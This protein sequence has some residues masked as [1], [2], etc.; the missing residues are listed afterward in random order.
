MA[1]DD[2]PTEE[3]V[4]VPAEPETP[5]ETPKEE[6]PE[7]TPEEQ[8][9][10]DAL[11]QVN[12][13][14]KG[15]LK[16]N[17]PLDEEPPEPTEEP[18]EP[19]ESE[20]PV[21]EAPEITPEADETGVYAPVTATDPGEFK[22]QDYS[23]TIQTTDGRTHKISTP[24]DAESFAS[25]LDT[26]PELIS[27][28]QFLALGRKSA[29]MEQ[30]IA[31]D[32][33]YFN[34]MK[35]SYEEQTAQAQT[36]ENYLNQWQGEANYLRQKGDLPPLTNE[37]TNAD[38]TDPEVA[39]QSGV[40]ETL[41][42]FKWMEEENTRRMNAGLPPDLSLVSAHTA[43]Q[44]EAMRKGEADADA[45]QKVTTRQRGAMVGK[46]S[47]YIP[48]NQSKGTIVGAARSLDD[49]ATEAYYAQQE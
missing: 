35:A 30:N 22:P 19:E 41:E 24:E 49:L 2:T 9:V 38:W 31:R 42:L 6:Q 26:N 18:E 46:R 43:M 23:F 15:E 3:P 47:P 29:M 34:Q 11:L 28:S 36:R 13:D 17:R 27:A 16:P 32:E 10:E 14:V 48:V 40:K 44:L 33:A 12:G 45:Q 1:K 5:V 20:I 8:Q 37:L 4:E 39:S 7:L 25:Q 21:E